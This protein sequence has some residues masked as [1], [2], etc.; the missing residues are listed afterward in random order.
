[1]D[2]PKTSLACC[3][4]DLRRDVRRPRPRFSGGR[5]EEDESAVSW[6]SATSCDCFAG[7][8]SGRLGEEVELGGEDDRAI[9]ASDRSRICGLLLRSSAGEES[10]AVCL[11][12]AA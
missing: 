3:A 10:D 5:C 11:D 6:G 4:T 2:G 1:M 8:G 9:G 7:S 12:G